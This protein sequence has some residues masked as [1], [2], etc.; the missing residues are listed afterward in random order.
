M[1]SQQIFYEGSNPLLSKHFSRRTF[2][3]LFAASLPANDFLPPGD[4]AHNDPVIS[5]VDLKKSTSFGIGAGGSWLRA[6]SLYK[7]ESEHT[8]AL[9]FDVSNNQIAVSLTKDGHIRQACIAV[10]LQR[11]PDAKIKG[12]VY[13]TKRLLYAGNWEIHVNVRGCES[14]LTSTVSML[15]NLLPLFTSVHDGVHVDR[16]MFVPADERTPERAPRTLLCL[17]VLDNRT[18]VAK[19][20]DIRFSRGEAADNAPLNATSGQAHD[21]GLSAACMKLYRLAPNSLATPVDIFTHAEYHI[22]SR[23]ISSIAFGM[24]L[25]ES[26]AE[27]TESRR[28]LTNKSLNLW[29][30]DTLAVRKRAYGSLSIEEAPLVADTL[31]RLGELARQS[32]LRLA[33][34]EVC[35]GFLGSDVDVN[36]VNWVRDFYYIMLAMS[37]F[38][39]ALCRDSISYLLRWGVS[40]VLTEGGWQRFPGAR[41]IS[42]SLSNSVSGLCLAGAYYKA[43][44]DL[45]F[46]RANS[47]IK[48][49]A[50]DIFDEV[51]A[52][53]RGSAMLFPSLHYSDGEARGDFH[54]GSNI[55]AWV[56][57]KSMARIAV[58]AY[59]DEG[60]GAAWAEVADS[61]REA[62]E[63]HCVGESSHG[64]RFFEG[65]NQD[66]TFINGH[67]GE[68]SET[69][70]LPFYGFCQPDDARL[71]IH[72]SMALSQENP[73][74][75]KHLDA[76]WWY[77]TS[78][79][80]AT[81]PGWITGLA[82][83]NDENELNYRLER[84]SKLLDFDGSVWWWPYRYGSEDADH[85][86]RGDVAKKCGWGGAVF[87][88]KFINDVLGISVDVPSANVNFAPFVPWNHFRWDDLHFGS[89]SFD[90]EYRSDS[91]AISLS[92]LNKQRTAMTATFTVIP[93]RHESLRELRMADGEILSHECVSLWGR[94]CLRTVLNMRPG[95]AAIVIAVKATPV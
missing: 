47:Q 11:L 27:C 72:A 92:L 81:F 41:P 94:S 20:V 39:P 62:I 67:D 43:T 75:S 70:L 49:Q 46:F 69:T 82:A 93:K 44:G 31:T 45:A 30:Q 35:G 63:R 51:L 84:I 17:I 40:P 58:D 8:S 66:G 50:K 68:E 33:S 73:L 90:A 38:E 59:S 83:A 21:L 71:R 88:C 95:E 36:Q 24:V 25:G 5:M 89:A 61:I 13:S 6:G 79:S 18:E 86:L 55:A 53:R 9:T 16:L 85:P 57:F 80:S 74:Y 3:Q 65:A 77:N 60:L 26:E 37:I 2:L 87:V 76:I 4:I 52:S 78:W 29:L 22:P 19:T 28:R 23:T 54:T 91:S 15:D 42:Q 7:I 56:A 48:Q 10:G 14:P 34:G 32:A 1:R 64:K 12:G